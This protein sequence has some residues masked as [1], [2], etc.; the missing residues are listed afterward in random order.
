MDDAFVIY[1]YDTP[2]MSEHSPQR[3]LKPDGERRLSAGQRTVAILPSTL[4]LCNL[5]CGFFA[6][7]LASRPLETPLP[8][9]WTPLTFA[10]VFLFVGM[11]FDGLDGSVA[12]LTRQTS[13]LG[14]QLDSMAD[15]VTFGVAP[16]FIVVQLMGVQTPFLS[17][18]GD[19]YLDRV[20]LAA[21]GI[22]VACVALRL[23][24]FN[25]ELDEPDEVDHL[26]FNGLP[27]PGAAGTVGSLVLLHQHFLS[28]LDS[29]HWLIQLT[30]VA[31]VGIM[32]LMAGAMVGRLQYVHVANRYVRG[33]AKF[34][35]FAMILMVVM[36]LLSAPQI[37]MAVGFV[38][39]TLSAPAMYLL[40]RGWRFRTRS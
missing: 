27:S 30:S 7:F 17:L 1:G 3:E 39:Y 13:E 23:A 14:E 16:A 33:R 37:S 34:G 15:M 26:I 22:Y 18:Q 25:A 36:L 38:T 32:L 20:S 28:Q 12:R 10:A 8:W 11:V 31:M 35:V 19:A 4:T 24:R 9:G 40:K 6:V 29:H 2:I 21:A 5:L